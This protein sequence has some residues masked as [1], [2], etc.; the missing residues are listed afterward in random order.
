[1]EKCA[2]SSF[3]PAYIVFFELLETV[4][5]LRIS[6]EARGILVLIFLPQTVYSH[7]FGEIGKISF[8]LRY[9][10]VLQY[11]LEYLRAAASFPPSRYTAQPESSYPDTLSGGIVFNFAQNSCVIYSVVS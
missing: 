3:G 4:R 6:K 10:S 7:Y 11:K 9:A 5:A 8:P 2:F 1:M